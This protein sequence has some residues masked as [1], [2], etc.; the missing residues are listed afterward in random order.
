MLP[1][2]LDHL[3]LTVASIE[4]SV[5]FY[6]EVLGF[7]EITFAGGRKA[8]RMGMQKINLHLSG[9]EIHPHAE[10]PTPGSGD[11]CIIYDGEV[12]A[13]MNHLDEAGVAIELG[14]VNRSGASGPITSVYIRDPDGNLIELCVYP[15]TS[16]RTEKLQG[17]RT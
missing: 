2:G 16:Q 3:V 15:H 12:D 14:P 13:I 8:V 7:E 10:F 4:S 9:E 6:R 1:L 5:R 11:L 17:R